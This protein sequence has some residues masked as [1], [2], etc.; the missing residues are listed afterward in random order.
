MGNPIKPPALA[1]GGT[2]RILSPASPTDPAALRRGLSELK[3]LGYVIKQS[4][5][6]MKP[7][8]YFAGSLEERRAELQAA[9]RENASPEALLCS[10]GGYGTSALLDALKLPASR[11][12][13][14]LQLSAK[15]LIGYSDITPLQAFLWKRLRW[16]T[17]YGPMVG[18]GFDKG[19]DRPGGYDRASFMNATSGARDTWALSLQGEPLSRG[20]ATGVLLGGC[21]T[22][23]E[24][25]LGTPWELD[26]RGAIL[27][28][29]DRAIRPYQLDRILVHLAQAGKLRGVRGFVLGDFP[30][31][32][33]PAGSRVTVRDVFRRILRPL[34]VPV[35]FGAPVG[36]TEW[37][38]L[39]LPLGVRA[40]LRAAGE[41]KLEIL[42]PAV[43]STSSRRA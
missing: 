39:T 4:P 41:G 29:E 43:Q 13:P 37:P 21:L 15:L 6:R 5:R 3:R 26:T 36:H 34:G 7:Q 9:L 8:G 30:E 25:T 20:E 42:E 10:R 18:A 19:A 14:K 22:L 40:R 12:R 11:S 17:L 32:G 1:P 35:L 16:V 38:M 24:T 27:V 31:C 23:I 2:V 33:P 28:L